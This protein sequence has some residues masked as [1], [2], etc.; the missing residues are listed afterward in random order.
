MSDSIVVIGN[1]EAPIWAADL[2]TPS[3][4]I[5]GKRKSGDNGDNN[6]S[7]STSTK[8][9]RRTKGYFFFSFHPS[10]EDG[11]FFHRF[12]DW[13]DAVAYADVIG[14]QAMV[15]DMDKSLLSDS[16]G[17][18]PSK[19]R[20]FIRLSNKYFEGSK[21]NLRKTEGEDL[22][23][24]EFVRCHFQGETCSAL[25]TVGTFIKHFVCRSLGTKYCRKPGYIGTAPE[26]CMYTISSYTHW[27]KTVV[28]I[29]WEEF[30][31]LM[32]KP[33]C[34][35]E[36]A[37]YGHFCCGGSIQVKDSKVLIDA[38]FAPL[39]SDHSEVT[40]C[41]LLDEFVGNSVPQ[42]LPQDVPEKVRLMPS[43]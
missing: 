39:S 28:N 6:N 25:A 43:C 5:G 26:W 31:S 9:R 10:P 19:V 23:S 34:S 11:L 8:K 20:Q 18:K 29:S 3:P 24:T 32:I 4:K 22:T 27:G 33:M 13:R 30:K 15:M 42:V 2:V 37:C 14:N 16:K 36:E 38:M 40:N 21:G 12:R 1:P 17:T 7:S 41:C 35:I